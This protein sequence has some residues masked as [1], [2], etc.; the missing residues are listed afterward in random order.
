MMSALAPYI[1]VG[2]LTCLKIRC[3]YHHPPKSGTF[4]LPRK[5]TVRLDLQHEG[6]LRKCWFGD[7]RTKL[8]G[9]CTGS[10]RG[11]FSADGCGSPA[12]ADRSSSALQR[13]QRRQQTEISSRL[14]MNK[15]TQIF[16]PQQPSL[17]SLYS[18]GRPSL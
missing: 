2:S 17:F 9:T 7:V 12:G 5:R 18:A 3:H 4:F 15:F 8:C 6:L 16:F 13:A 14:Q 1:P 10:R 11:T